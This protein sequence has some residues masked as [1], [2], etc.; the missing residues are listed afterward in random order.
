VLGR[1]DV[2][3]MTGLLRKLSVGRRL[4]AGFALLVVLLAVVVGM[5]WQ[6]AGTAVSSTDRS[7][8]QARLVDLARVADKDAA[9]VALDENSIAFDINSG[10]DPAG[11]QQSYT[12]DA[13]TAAQDLAALAALPLTAAQTAQ[14]AAARDAFT[15][16][17]QLSQRINDGLGSSTA[18]SRAAANDLVG[19]LSYGKVAKPLQELVSSVTNQAA[20]TTSAE[21]ASAQRQKLWDAAVGAVAVVVALLAGLL[22]SRSITRPL[23]TAVDALSAVAAGDLTGRLAADGDDELTLLAGAV[24]QVGTRLGETVGRLKTAAAALAASSTGLEAGTDDVARGVGEA[25]RQAEALAT[26]SQQVTEHVSSVAAGTEEMGA[27]IREIARN[28]AD[29]AR[30]ASEAVAAAGRTSANVAALGESSQQVGEVVKLITTIAQQTNLL[31]L[32][33]TIE[34][35]R[36][37]EA[38]LGFAV[39]AGEVKDLAQETAKATEDITA[40]IHA[41]Q[42]E[43]GSAVTAIQHVTEVI[44]AIDSYQTS[45]ASAVEEQA[46][47]TQQ[48]SASVSDAARGVQGIAGSIDGVAAAARTAADGVAGSRRTSAELARMSGELERLVGTFQV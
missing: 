39:V 35:A 29:A 37:G 42:A 27:A 48:M 11:D 5:A 22:I 12:D 46:A 1:V 16:Y 30:V 47:T 32:N 21:R 44:G 10:S 18:A 38:G 13:K 26:A 2:I 17:T 6:G 4:A 19:Q 40:R 36:A 33:A 31:A 25:S 28:A 43:T 41:M 9:L 14:L 23:R 15:T 24:N 45:I 3:R 8:A 34:A 20:A 7:R